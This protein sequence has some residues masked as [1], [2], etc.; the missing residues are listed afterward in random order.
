MFRHI[1][2][3]AIGSDN[4][5][6]LISTRRLHWTH[7]RRKRVNVKLLFM[8]VARAVALLQPQKNKRKVM[9]NE[10]G[11]EKYNTKR[12]VRNEHLTTFQNINRT[13]CTFALASRRAACLCGCVCVCF[14]FCRSLC[15]VERIRAPSYNC[16]SKLRT[17]ISYILWT[18][19]SWCRRASCTWISEQRLRSYREARDGQSAHSNDQ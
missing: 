2:V 8:V 18:F 3:T 5:S 1:T 17:N 10:S 12:S 9:G 7:F 11:E 14:H 13:L 6:T 15:C 16:E 19:F 4:I